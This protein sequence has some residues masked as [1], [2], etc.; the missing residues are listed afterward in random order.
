VD[1]R[2]ARLVAA[3]WGRGAAICLLP[4]LVG[5]FLAGTAYGR[6][7]H[8]W[9]A[10]L[11]D[12]DVYLKAARTLQGGG[13]IYNLPDGSLPFLYPPFAAILAVPMTWLP[14]TVVQMGWAVGIALTVVAVLHRF[15]LHGWRLSLI[16]AAAVRLVEPINQTVAFGQLGVFLVGLV[17]LDLVPGPRVFPGRKRRLPEGLLVGFATA[18]KLTPG[19]FFIYLLAIRR[20]KAAILAVITMIIATLVALVAAPRSSI[21]FW[22]R[23][24]RGDSG[25]GGSII[26][27]MNQ[28]ILGAAGRI[29][30]YNALGNAIGLALSAIIAAVGVLTAAWWHRRGDEAMA[31][32]LCGVTTLLASPVSWSHHFVWIAPLGVL[33]AL[34]TQWPAVFRIIG[35]LFVGWVVT[36]PWKFLPDGDNVERDFFWWQNLFAAITP[37]LGCLLLVASLILVWRMAPAS[38]VSVAADPAVVADRQERSPARS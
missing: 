27:L 4:C 19:L 21:D 20:Y 34:R 17:V 25:L 9:R 7:L 15:G 11:V 10:G 38:P 23:L 29:F 31:V 26:Y 32:T 16:S 24:A 2:N 5:V 12:L 33:M 14:H 22:S 28:S 13:D 36:T 18:V 37:A 8:P 6:P 1:S 30:G 3:R 35:W